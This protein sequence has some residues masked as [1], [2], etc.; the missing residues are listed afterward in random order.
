MGAKVD[1]TNAMRMLDRADIPYQV[2]L[3]ECADGK[4][5]GV[6]VAQKLGQDVGCVY[7]TLV[8]KGTGN[9]YV[10]VVP[11]AQEL[12]LKKAAKAV[13]E[14]AIE[15]IHVAEINK[16]TGYV[17]GGCSPIGMKK[18]FST[19]FDDSVEK[20]AHIMVSGGRIGYQIELDPKALIRLLQGK[21]AQITAC[22]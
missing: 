3:Y 7:K 5:D 18:Q 16:V 17:R 13:G 1:K 20:Q 8:T 10:F 9:Y 2:H 4:I 14:K 19:V 6:S 12:D 11:V 21:T 15:M 22:L